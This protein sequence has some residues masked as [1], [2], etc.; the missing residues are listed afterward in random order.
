MEKYVYSKANDFGGKINIKRLQDSIYKNNSI[1]VA[2]SRIDTDG[3][4]VDIWM[5]DVLPSGQIT[6][7][8]STISSHDGSPNQ[9]LPE[10]VEITNKTTQD[11]RLLVA[12][13]KSD[14][15]SADFYTHRWNDKTTWYQKSI[16]VE[17]EVATDTG[18]SLTHDLSNQYL[19]DTYHGKLTR[20]NGLLDSLG[21]PYRISA[22]INGS[23]ITEQDPHYGVGGDYTANYPS[24]QITLLSLPPSGATVSVTYHYATTSEFEIKPSPGKNLSIE[25]VDVQFSEDIELKD[26][27][28]FS[29]YGNVEDFA[30]SLMLPPPS[31]YSLPSGTPIQLQSFEYK[32]MDDY[33]AAAI[34]SFVAYPPL[35]GNGWRGQSKSIYTLNWDYRRTICLCST[36]GMSMVL[37]LLHDE[38]FNGTY[39]SATF[40]CGSEDE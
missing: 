29:V 21:N 33:Y 6:F 27:I 24:G 13:E 34:R 37:K 18:D 8:N 35:G 31:G 28:V 7:L 30:P 16:R 2:P 32:T 12:V 36:K 9:V 3:D 4:V 5:K 15:G 11:N 17:D 14:G 25:V 22:S 26:S 20:E 19:I 38:P 1:T 39:T 10:V 40:Y 23:G